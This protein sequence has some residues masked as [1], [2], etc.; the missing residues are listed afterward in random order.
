MNIGL[1]NVS[2]IRYS[3]RN[4]FR[5]SA[6]LFCCFERFVFG[7]EIETNIVSDLRCCCKVILVSKSIDFQC[8]DKIILL[9]WRAARVNKLILEPFSIFR[10]SPTRPVDHQGSLTGTVLGPIW[11]RPSEPSNPEPS[12]TSSNK[13]V[14]DEFSSKSTSWPPE[15]KFSR[16]GQGFQNLPKR[17]QTGPFGTSLCQNRPFGLQRPN[18]PVLVKASRTVQNVDARRLA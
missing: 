16:F 17:S 15:A 1:L 8:C 4:L 6:L 7:F 14:L 9:R 5:A 11:S 18:F 12:K 10:V 3:F 2:K 13:P